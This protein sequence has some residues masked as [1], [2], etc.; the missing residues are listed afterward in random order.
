MAP[1]RFR[2]SLK[3]RQS[4]Q[5]VHV[6]GRQCSGGVPPS[7]IAALAGRGGVQR[8]SERAVGGG[9]GVP[10]ADL[11][12]G[13]AAS[14]SRV[15]RLTFSSQCGT[16]RP[17]NAASGKS[18]GTGHDAQRDTKR[19]RKVGRRHSPPPPAESP[20]PF[21]S[22]ARRCRGNIRLGSLERIPN[23]V[24]A[25]LR[26]ARLRLAARGLPIN[27]RIPRP[28]EPPVG[29]GERGERKHQQRQKSAGIEPAGE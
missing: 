25:W 13:V 17:F 9:A 27:V 24:Q 2:S 19:H 4:R 10:V 1:A 5:S 26:V 6:P 23:P 11:R 12:P 14:K 21:G 15:S 22:I 3:K 20:A 28:L 29:W 16:R 8:G 7:G 18:A